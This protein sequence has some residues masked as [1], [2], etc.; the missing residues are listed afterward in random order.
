MHLYYMPSLAKVEEIKDYN[1]G[2]AGRGWIGMLVSI[3][4]CFFSRLM[5]STEGY[6]QA[7]EVSH[8]MLVNL[9]IIIISCDV[10]ILL[11]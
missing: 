7:W 10:V 3:D 6:W 5:A 4:G 9:M 2:G 11:S 1:W 8:F